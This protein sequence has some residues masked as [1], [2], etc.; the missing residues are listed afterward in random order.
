MLVLKLAYRG[1]IGA[2]LKTW[3]KVVVLSMSYFFIIW[4]QGL[5]I[6]MYNS[7]RRHM[8]RDDIAGGHYRQEDYDPFNPLSIDDA[9]APVPAELE[10]MVKRGEA[11]PVLIA[12]ATIYPGGRVKTVL[13]KGIDPAQKTVDMPVAALA[14]SSDNLPVMVGKRMAVKNGLKKGDV[15]TVRWRD[16]K[17]TFD[18]EEGVITEIMD[19]MVPTIDVNQIWVPIEKL[20]DMTGLRGEAT[21]VVIGRDAEFP[22][23]LEGW[24][25]QTQDDL[26]ADLKA[27]INADRTSLAVMLT[28]LLLLAML[29]IFDTQ[30]LSIFR[31]RREIGTLMA[32]GMGRFGV[33]SLFT[34]EGALV[35]VLA[36]GVGLFYSAPV[37][38]YTAVKGISIPGSDKIDDYGFAIGSR[39]YGIFSAELIAAVVLMIMTVTTVVSYLPARKIA[40]MKPT[41]ALKGRVT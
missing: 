34:I 20:R 23:K 35:G 16:R 1:L 28:M 5:Y 7:A 19:T 9:H 11:M 26:L 32:L 27:G 17:G 24:S 12:N 39:M 30:I 13:M 38:Y 3:L 15:M 25:F 36:A 29:A 31:R 8:I 2:G 40:G 41:E 33:V 18:A 10:P 14:G 21:V 6:G 4:T 22:G 37:L